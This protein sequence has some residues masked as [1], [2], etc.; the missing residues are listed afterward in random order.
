[1]RILFIAPRLPY[2]PL[3]GYQLRAWHQVR[4]LSQRH[5]VTL[6]C[7]SEARDSSEAFRRVANYCEEIITVPYRAYRSV[8][9]VCG[10]IARGLP[11]QS[12]IYETPAMRCAID[13][14]LAEKRH[15]VAHVQLA[16]MA[17]L[18]AGQTSMPRVIDLVDALSLN[19]RRRGSLDRGP[20]RQIAKAEANRLLKYEREICR[21]WDRAFVVS[22]IDRAAIGDFP[23]LIVNP[24][25]VDL[26]EFSFQREGRN[27]H[28]ILFTGNLGY[29]SNVDAISWFARAIFPRIAQQ[30]PMAKLTIVGARPDRK[31]RALA[32]LDTRI[33][34]PGWVE[35]LPPYLHRCAVAIAPMRAGS[36]QLFKV[37]EAMACGAPMV[38]TRVVADATAAQNGRHVMVAD[39]PEAFADAVARLMREGALAARIALEAR[40]LVETEYRWERSVSDLNAI[41]H[42]AIE[43]RS[44]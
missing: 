30:D 24:S 18:L 37:L 17:G 13:R 9:A 4:L 10:A 11:F 27:P 42:S 31:V 20:L 1:M 6:V 29:F 34:A 40:A 23:N 43:N 7:Y 5:S 41:Y 35:K 15:E 25:G 21:S 38:V 8:A 19:L 36:G 28:E 26:E 22:P 16:R 39:T 3:R 33:T 2:P 12:A 44:A 14:V 32:K